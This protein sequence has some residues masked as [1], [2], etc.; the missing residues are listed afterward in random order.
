MISNVKKSKEKEVGLYGAF[1]KLSI[2]MILF[3]Q[4]FRFA[5]EP[6]FFKH[7]KEKNSKKIYADV[8]KYF[9]IIT[10][11]IFLI[12]VMFYDFIILFFNSTA[13]I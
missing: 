12:V 10:S 3:I 7:E 1:Y 9:V 4:T 6:F 11:L 8:M 13:S 2:L 5:A